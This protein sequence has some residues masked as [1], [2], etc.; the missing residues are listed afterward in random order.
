MKICKYCNVEFKR[1]EN[2]VSLRGLGTYHDE[3]YRNYLIDKY[4]DND[5]SKKVYKTAILDR[6]KKKGKQ[7][8]R[9]RQLKLGKDK[10]CQDRELFF[11]Y[12]EE[13]YGTL[14]KRQ[15]IKIAQVVSGKYKGLK[16][17]IPYHDLLEMFKGKK[18][19]LTKIFAKNVADGRMSKN[20]N[21]FDYD[22]A[23]LITKYDSFKRWKQNKKINEINIKKDLKERKEDAKINYDNKSKLNQ[24]KDN[25]DNLVS[26]MIDDLF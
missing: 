23:I 22:L 25:N 14:N 19:T 4:G 8:E 3:C 17:G 24:Q 21:R 2:K 13:Q 15:C 9:N 1:G 11:E 5:Y 16:E 18:N 10:E 26:D 6:N 7:Q 20:D 12:I